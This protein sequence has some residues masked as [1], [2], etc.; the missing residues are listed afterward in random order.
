MIDKISNFAE[1]HY[2]EA[3][4]LLKTLGK[5]PAPSRQEDQRAEFCRNWFLSQGASRVH[6]DPMK[7]VICEVPGKNMERA[8][9]FMAHMDVVFDDLE[10]LPMRQEGH[11]LYAPGIGDDTANLVNTM[12]AYKFMLEQKVQP[13]KT[14]YFVANSCEEGLGNLDGCREFFR[15]YGEK[16]DAFYSFDGYQAQCTSRAVGSHRYRVSVKVEGGHSYLE[17]G[18]KNAIYELAKLIDHLYQIVP[19][20]EAKTTF[21]VGRIEGGSTV[22]TIAETASMLYEFRS[23]SADC[24]QKMETLFMEQVEQA[25]D[26]DVEIQVE[27]LGIRPGS[28]WDDRTLLEAWTAENQKIIQ[29]WY[30]ETLDLTAYSTDANIPLSGR[31]LAN[32]IGTVI[33]GGAHTREEWIDLE[34]LKTGM[35]ITS[36]FVSQFLK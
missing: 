30:Q 23:E 5:I 24:L 18:K 32:T 10:M 22:N 8:V 1:R 31:I 20:S 27:T 13:E 6:I 16:I 9:V 28:A 12:M 7:N 11:R 33:G 14:L 34:S 26:V 21:N 17:F 19:P 2:E 15:A 35:A 29:H 36:E 4:E 25:R 3:K